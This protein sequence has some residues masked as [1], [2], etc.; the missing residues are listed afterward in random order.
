[1]CVEIHL[2]RENRT[3]NGGFRELRGLNVIF[4]L[5][6]P[7]RHILA[8]NHVV[9]RILRE[10]RFWGLDCE[11][12]EE[13]GEK[14]PSKHLWCAISRIGGKEILWGFVTEFCL[15][16]DIRDVITYATFWWRSVMG[17]DRGKGSNFP[18]PPLT[19]VVA[20]TT[21]SHYRASVW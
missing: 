15:W 20:L 12:F 8:R 7:K 4:C 13:P 14:K 17:F 21:L 10:N 11:P 5:I 9:W 16:V 19:C 6:T 18:F 2:V 1:M 3:Q